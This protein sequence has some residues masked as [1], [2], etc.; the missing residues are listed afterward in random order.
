LISVLLKKQLFFFKKL[1]EKFLGD[2]YINAPGI[3][4]LK[5]FPEVRI[6]DSTCFQL[7][8]EMADKY[9]GS[10]GASSKA[11][12]RIQFEYDI[13]T[14]KVIDLSLHP[15]NT[16]D[17]V[18]AESSLDDIAP[19]V[20]LLRD[21]GYISTFVL[22][23]IKEREAFYICRL[24]QGAS[25]FFLVDGA[26]QKMDFAKIWAYMKNNKL[27][28]IEK[29]AYITT[30]LEKVRMIIELMPEEV[31]EERIRKA[32][33]EAKKKGRKL[34]KEYKSRARLNIFITNISAEVLELEQIHSVYTLRW[35]IELV[36]KVWKSIGKIHKV[37]KMKQERFESYLYAKL[38]W[39]MLNWMIIWNIHS[40][41]YNTHKKL[42]SFYKAFDS[43]KEYKDDFKFALRCGNKGLTEFLYDQI[44]CSCKFHVM[45]K[46]KKGSSLY[47]LTKIM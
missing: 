20:L 43:L 31:V 46:K 39:L 12:V 22:K 11:A 45:E 44:F 5:S 7:P 30:E 27:S 23:G 4:F 40:Y 2:F 17:S 35:Q 38:L 34:S 3:E 41:L 28:K 47:N 32:E 29:E 14:G 15:F 16:Q 18:N 42:L 1:I 36:F 6:K 26:Y 25:A 21:L 8:E 33:K 10:G 9:P 13:K 37:K 24:K 19:N